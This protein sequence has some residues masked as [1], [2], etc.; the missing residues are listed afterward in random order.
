MQVCM[1][2]WT[3]G[4]GVEDGNDQ[5]QYAVAVLKAG[6]IVGHIPRDLSRIFYFFLRRG[7]TID[8]E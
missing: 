4:V 1:D 7:G 6:T 5:D 8:Y 2:S 3:P